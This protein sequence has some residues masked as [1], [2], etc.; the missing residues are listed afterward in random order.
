MSDDT[1]EALQALQE[2]VR[3]RVQEQTLLAIPDD[4]LEKLVDA[5]VKRFL[6]A[7]TRVNGYGREERVPSG[8]E[9][10]VQRELESKARDLIKQRVNQIALTG[11]YD[12][13]LQYLNDAVEEIVTKR[14]GQI[15]AR[16]IGNFINLNDLRT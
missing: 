15:L 8:L 2:T 7:S 13:Q 11:H 12:E 4:M 9:I 14:A 1:R 5:E 10:M 6:F 3:Q 16:A